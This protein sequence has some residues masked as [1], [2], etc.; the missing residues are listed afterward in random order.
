MNAVMKS[1]QDIMDS[2]VT[3]DKVKLLV[4][5]LVLSEMWK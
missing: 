4:Y 3:F 1:D 5:D 2:C